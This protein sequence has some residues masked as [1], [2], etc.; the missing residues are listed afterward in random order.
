[1]ERKINWQRNKTNAVYLFLHTQKKH[2]MQT[3]WIL[4]IWR[5][6]QA[7][8]SC[9][10][11]LKVKAQ[12]DSQNTTQKTQNLIKHNNVWQCT[13]Q[14]TQRFRKTQ[15]FTKDILG[16][17][18]THFFYL[19]IY[20]LFQKIQNFKKH[21]LIRFFFF[22]FYQMFENMTIQEHFWKQLQF[23]F[24][25]FSENILDETFL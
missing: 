11:A 21:N 7:L 20:L 17:Q 19:F 10:V 18:Q 1:M 4:C 5:E 2:D 3:C 16:K 13:F 23:C 12:Q 14:N 8:C 24:L 9:T 6:L 15:H 25:F 22:F